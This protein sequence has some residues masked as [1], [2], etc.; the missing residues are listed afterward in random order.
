[1]PNYIITT[2]ANFKPFS[3]DELLSPV[4]MAT[5][6][7]RE[8]EDAYSDLGSEAS[9]WE[10]L[11]N[12]APDKDAYNVYKNYSN[13]LQAQADKLAKEGLTP[14]SRRDLLN[15]KRRYSSDIKPIEEA[16]TKREADIKDYKTQ[17]TKDPTL[18]SGDNNPMNAS[19]TSYMNGNTPTYK[20]L[21][22]EDLYKQGLTA[23]TALSKGK[24]KE[25]KP[26]LEAGKQYWKMVTE[27]GYSPDEAAQWLANNGAFPEITAEVNR[28]KEAYNTAGLGSNSAAADSQ[29]IR[30]IM[31]G[32]HAGYTK[33]VDR[34]IYRS[35]ND[36]PK[37]NIIYDELGNGYMKIGEK[38]I[39]VNKDGAFKLDENGNP[40]IFNTKPDKPDDSASTNNRF[41][42]MD[43][44]KI[45]AKMI[46]HDADGKT[47]K[48][49]LNSVLNPAEGN[50]K[51]VGT[52]AATVDNNWF[53]EDEVKDRLY[54]FDDDAERELFKI[55]KKEA[56][57]TSPI[58]DPN[59]G[60]VKHFEHN[61]IMDNFGDMELKALDIKDLYNRFGEDG[62]KVLDIVPSG[63]SH[64][65]RVYKNSPLG[66]LLNKFTNSTLAD[67]TAEG[68]E[69]Y[70]QLN[71][72]EWD[73]FI[74]SNL[75]FLEVENERKGLNNKGKAMS[76]ILILQQQ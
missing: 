17:L 13:D 45:P 47:K 68:K 50:F 32:L 48:H 64:V 20:Y 69:R 31:D 30:G 24:Y 40:I 15:M 22:G 3:Y 19:L 65:Y 51:H 55:S 57:K 70:Y 26:V 6:E 2:K 8:I 60:E 58:V 34:Q 33:D 53:S 16:W 42:P 4:L 46:I 62:T 72:K 44:S 73:S 29:I 21:S 56:I 71:Q 5:K 41:T 37:N 59:S 43:N 25:S 9:V 39:A 11:A 14:N 66:K 27:Q 12:S 38:L 52:I 76:D 49:T 63:N 54:V 18:L 10:K 28:I 61:N 23:A 74:N 7:H 75:L 67:A 1:M 35:S 36:K